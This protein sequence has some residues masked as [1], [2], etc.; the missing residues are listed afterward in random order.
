MRRLVLWHSTPSVLENCAVSKF[1]SFAF[2]LCTITQQIHPKI[3][4]LSAKVYD[5]KYQ[6]TVTL[7]QASLQPQM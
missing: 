3:W 6:K 4:Q 2:L 7:V 1:M 5:T